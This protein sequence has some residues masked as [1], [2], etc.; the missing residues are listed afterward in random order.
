MT[1]TYTIDALTIKL[2]GK[3]ATLYRLLKNGEVVGVYETK[4]EAEAAQAAL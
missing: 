4:A 1:T 3:K 2:F